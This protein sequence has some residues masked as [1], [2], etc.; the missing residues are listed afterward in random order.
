M[1][2]TCACCG[3]SFDGLLLD[4]AYRCP[5]AY[6]A[7]P[8]PRESDT[9][10]LSSDFCR[11]DDA[12]FLRACLEIPVLGL[13]QPFVWGVWVA[14]DRATWDRAAALF[15]ADPAPDEP[16]YAALLANRLQDYPDTLD[17]RARIRFRPLPHRP[18]VALE[19]DDHDI[20]GDQRKGITIERVKRIVG[21]LM[22]R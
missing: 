2:W 4:V 16:S 21:P 22:H 3:R 14:V 6:E 19:P 18:L 10:G 15:E 20:A 8:D 7:L 13:E 12:L 9:V 1:R 17:L 11:V 5:S